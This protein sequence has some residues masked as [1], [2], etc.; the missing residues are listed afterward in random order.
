MR[1]CAPQTPVVAVATTLRPCGCACNYVRKLHHRVARGRG[2]AVQAPESGGQ[3]HARGHLPLPQRTA[4]ATGAAVVVSAPFDWAA[5]RYRRTTA[6]MSRSGV[7]AEAAAMSSPD[8]R[9]S[10]VDAA[11]S[12][13]ND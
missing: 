11:V 12:P 6:L 7:D 1:R 4:P 8:E 10:G 5:C 9:V 2:P 3:G 13:N